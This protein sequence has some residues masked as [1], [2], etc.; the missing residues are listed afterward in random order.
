LNQSPAPH[1]RAPLAAL[2]LL[3]FV[4]GAAGCSS[5][6]APPTGTFCARGMSV[7]GGAPPEGFCLKHY[8][9]VGEARTLALA[10]NGD[11][12]VAAP[13][14]GTSGF[15][16]GGPGAIIILSDDDHDGLAEQHTFLDGIEDVHGL[17]FDGDSLVFTTAADVWRTPYVTGQRAETPGK[18]VSLGLPASYETNGRWT[19]GLARSVKGQLLTSRGDYGMCGADATLGGS[20]SKLGADGTLEPLATHLRNPMYLRCHFA[21]DVCAAMELGEDL[22][23]GAR[24]K[25]L[26]LRAGTQYGFPCCYTT[27]LPSQTNL[28]TNA[29]V[30]CGEVTKEDASFTLSNTPFGFDWERGL[31]PAPYKGA[32]FVALHGSAYSAMQYEGARIVYARTDPMTHAPIEAWQEFLG[33]FSRGGSTLSR[34]ADV[35]FAPD[36]RMFFADDNGGR[37]YW[38]APTSLPAPN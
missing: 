22:S 24:E 29:M 30:G 33:G 14:R 2:A 3:T 11:L 4:A 19:H 15:A 36:G 8:A 34:P 12:F 18:R 5:A 20:V 1:R 35:L 13:S 31:W 6:A 38:M 10:P 28:D 21:A 23:T 16:S 17:V 37:V 9:Q 32:M 27:D 7:L 26:M 25:L